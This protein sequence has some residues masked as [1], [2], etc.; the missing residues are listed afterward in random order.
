MALIVAVVVAASATPLFARLARRLDIVDRPGPLKVQTTPV[1]YLGGLAVLVGLLGPTLVARPGLAVPF[2]AAALL[3]LADDVA[4]LRLEVRVVVELAIGIAVPVALG[5][6]AEAVG[7]AA[8]VI[9]V[10]V[11]AVN[12]LDGLDGLAS[13]V[14]CASAL[15]FAV[16]LDG[17]L[18]TIAL[19]LA[20]ALAGFLLW[21]RPPARVYLGDAG[22]YLIG[23]ALGA[24]AVGT[25]RP[26]GS[27]PVTAAALLLLGVPVG[28]MTVA[29]VRRWRAG[30]PLFA[31]DRGHVYDQLTAHG[32]TAPRAAGACV[33][34]QVALVGL[35]VGVAELS[36]GPAVVAAAVV[37]VVC[38]TWA[39]R[40]FTSPS[41]WEPG[42]GHRPDQ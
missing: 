13:G 7:P 6:P 34:A 30:R 12:L 39:L 23:T 38:G 24:V 21:N 4:D 31:G 26:G 22:S 20:G 9:L 10:L 42:H 19:G 14:A 5:L 25:L 35:A 2:A 8:L 37:V 40:A 17:D 1:A 16:I 32:W 27:L 28:D 36:D 15:G 11:N 33:L 29:L 18:R 3:G 41:S